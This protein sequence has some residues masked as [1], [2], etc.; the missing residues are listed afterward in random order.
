MAEK[1]RVGT[2]IANCI[3]N[4]FIQEDQV[5]Y[6]YNKNN[7]LEWVGKAAF[8][9]IY[10]DYIELDN[11]KF[12]GCELRINESE[13]EPEPEPEPEPVKKVYYS[14][15]YTNIGEL[16]T[17]I[18]WFDNYVDAK[19]FALNVYAYTDIKRHTFTN[20]KRIKRI[21]ALVRG[22]KEV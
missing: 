21:E 18:A 7:N 14:L 19:K 8:A 5:V 11:Y 4:G 10:L 12:V 15:E 13:L 1:I 22:I 17:H 9:P 6:Y 20:T 2:F 16:H 3:I